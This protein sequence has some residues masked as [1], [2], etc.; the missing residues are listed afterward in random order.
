ML[1]VGEPVVIRNGSIEV[2]KGFMR[3][4]VTK[5][6]KITPHPDGIK[7]TPPAPVN[8]KTENNKSEGE[9]STTTSTSSSSGGGGGTKSFNS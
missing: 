7:S 9:L 8:I 3:L 2:F 6:G 1:R 4:V 5:W